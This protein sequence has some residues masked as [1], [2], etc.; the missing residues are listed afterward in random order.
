MQ[1][2]TGAQGVIYAYQKNDAFLEN[3]STLLLLFGKYN[4][5]ELFT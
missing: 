2:Q 1:A 4:S 5:V 3:M